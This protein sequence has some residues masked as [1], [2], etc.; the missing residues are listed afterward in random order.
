MGIPLRLGRD[1]RDS[2]TLASPMVAVVSESFARQF[3]PGENPLGQHFTMAF[4]ERTIAGVVGN[5]RV[6]GLERDSEPQVYLPPR[7]VPD[8]NVMNYAPKD[9]VI[10]A[11]GDPR[12]LAPAVRRIIAR[13]DPE[14]AV[15]DVQMLDEIV[16]AERAPRVVQVRVLS[17][18]A[19]L[20]CLLAATG[21]HALLSFALSTRTREIGVRVALG[22]GRRDILAMMLGQSLRHAA[23]GLAFGLVIALL[24]G[25]AMRGLLFGVEPADAG[26][27]LAATGLALVMTLAGTLV[28][29]FRALGVSPVVAMRVE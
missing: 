4:A 21:I 2:D 8:G 14:Q 18:F 23:I 15:A 26:T 20:A 9:L 6:R 17:G 5:V 24:T 22:A 12:A 7:Q 29:A 10:R 27:L 25:Q 16:D 28:P 19:V 1:V 3:W 13:A 11:S